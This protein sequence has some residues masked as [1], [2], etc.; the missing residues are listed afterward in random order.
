MKC[1]QGNDQA[2]IT[3]PTKGAVKVP[4]KWRGYA[5][6]SLTVIVSKSAILDITWIVKQ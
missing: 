3:K 4:K 6:Y 5:F 2:K 1:I